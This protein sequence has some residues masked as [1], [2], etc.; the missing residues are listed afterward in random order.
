MYIFIIAMFKMAWQ[1]CSLVEFYSSVV[2]FWLEEELQKVVASQDRG[3]GLT[4]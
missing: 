2:P 4:G 3:A 1:F